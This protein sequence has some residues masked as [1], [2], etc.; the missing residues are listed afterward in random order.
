MNKLIITISFFCVFTTANAQSLDSLISLRQTK[1]LSGK[2]PAF[3]TPEY[4]REA[5]Q[6]QSLVTSAVNYYEAELGKPFNLK[7]AV[8]DTSQWLKEIV[9]YG[10]LFYSDGWMVMNTGMNYATFK[11]VYG[12]EDFGADLD[13]VLQLEGITPEEVIRAFNAVYAIHEVGHYY[14]Y[15]LAQVNVPDSWNGEF[16]STYFSYQ[17]FINNNPDQLVIFELFSRINKEK[18]KPHYTTI[19]D[20]NEIYDAMGVK[21]YLWYHSNMYFL[22]KSLY[23][24]YGTTFIFEYEKMFPVNSTE[25][26]G[27]DEIIERLDKKCNGIV[28]KWVK[29]LESFNSPVK[30]D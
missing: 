27:L 9:P 14:Y 19:K 1:C 10:F 17:Y 16:I 15:N 12:L 5:M 18:F 24:C 4:E 2:V 23:E 7:L 13:S 26:P 29:A 20:L 28:L 21:N 11:N 3:Y 8:L 25:K 22:V 6:L 30:T